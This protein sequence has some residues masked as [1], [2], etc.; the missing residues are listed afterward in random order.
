MKLHELSEFNVLDLDQKTVKGLVSQVCPEIK[1]VFLEF[2]KDN[3]DA[4]LFIDYD[5]VKEYVI[6]K[7]EQEL[8]VEQVSREVA[9]L[10]RVHYGE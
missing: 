5:D 3:L 7:F 8:N 10:C 1:Q 4:W 2:Y 6:D 9:V